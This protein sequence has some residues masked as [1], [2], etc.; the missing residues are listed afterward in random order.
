MRFGVKMTK[1][2]IIDEKPMSIPELKE[3]LARIKARDKELTFRGNKAE[4][5]A[6]QFAVLDSKKAEELAEKLGKINVPRLK[7]MHIKKIVDVMPATP[8][9]VKVVLQGYTVTVKAEHVKKIAET[10]AGFVPKK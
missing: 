10:V 3:S 2:T 1:P 9:E 5:Y 8:D 6:N 7:E 4:D